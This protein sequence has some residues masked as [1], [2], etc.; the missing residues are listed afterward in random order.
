VIV[1]GQ[2]IL[3]RDLGRIAYTSGRRIEP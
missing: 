2:E 3:L 1:Q